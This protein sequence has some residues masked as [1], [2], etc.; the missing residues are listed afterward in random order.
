MRSGSRFCSS[1]SGGGLGWGRA[2]HPSDAL[3]APIP[4]FPQR[5]KE[6]CDPAHGFA[7]SPA[8]GGLGWGQAVYPWDALPA[9]IPTFP[10]RGKEQDIRSA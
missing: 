8:G 10:R 2:A 1:P 7:P 9:P 6:Q 4:T 3:P 5:G